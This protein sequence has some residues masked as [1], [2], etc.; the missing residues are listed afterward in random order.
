[1]F[2]STFVHDSTHTSLRLSMKW[3]ILRNISRYS[4]ILRTYISVPKGATW[5]QGRARA[6]PANH[7]NNI[8]VSWAF[9]HNGAQRHKMLTKKGYFGRLNCKNAYISL[10]TIKSLEK[11][12]ISSLFSLFIFLETN[13]D[14]KLSFTTHFY[15]SYTLY[16]LYTLHSNGDERF[17]RRLLTIN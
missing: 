8:R 16:L 15:I 14:S 11:S 1:M 4:G 9:E 3:V 2:L 17:S 7:N 12:I 6:K 10:K 13:F 5:A